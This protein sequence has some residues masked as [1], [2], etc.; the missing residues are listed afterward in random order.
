VRRVLAVVLLAS[1][2]KLL[3]AP[4]GLV[5]SIGAAALVGGAIGWAWLRAR[6]GLAPFVWQQR[7]RRRSAAIASKLATLP[8]AV[9]PLTS[10]SA[11]EGDRYRDSELGAKPGSQRLGPG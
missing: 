1:G 2:A 6:H 8:A 7:R 10:G 4:T 3:G 5:L 11:A 9:Q